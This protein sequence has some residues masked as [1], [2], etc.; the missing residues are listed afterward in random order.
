[1]KLLVV[2]MLA[3]IPLCCHAGS[4]CQELEELMDAAMN[5][6]VSVSEYQEMMNSYL[7]ISPMASTASTAKLKQCFLRQS[8]ET[9][10]NVKVMMNTIYNAKC[11]AFN[12][13]QDP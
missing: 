6:E 12:L 2:F 10:A 3:A 13:P 11:A 1:M 5:P 8:T 7:V 9:L 4:G